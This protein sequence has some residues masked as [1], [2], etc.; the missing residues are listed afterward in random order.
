MNQPPPQHCRPC[1]K[2]GGFPGG[3][4]RREIEGRKRQSSRALSP[5]PNAPV[6]SAASA[7]RSGEEGEYRRNQHSAGLWPGFREFSQRCGREKRSR[8]SL[9]IVARKGR[10]DRLRP[11]AARRI[12][13]RAGEFE[14]RGL[15]APP[16]L[17]RPARRGEDQAVGQPAWRR[18]GLYGFRCPDQT[19]PY[20]SSSSDGSFRCDG[21]NAFVPVRNR[22][23]R[24]EIAAR[25][26]I[27]AGRP[28]LC[29]CTAIDTGAVLVC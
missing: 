4:R 1:Q 27:P 19:G 20:S 9:S 13:G 17:V 8:R 6:R 5:E 3:G 15:G 22:T 16:V 24:H 26:D 23:D 10:R 7:A 11:R 2:A 28:M 12:N 25:F 18:S 21:W 14:G 29:P